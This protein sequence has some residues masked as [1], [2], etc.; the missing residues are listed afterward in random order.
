MRTGTRCRRGGEGPC[1]RDAG[2][3]CPGIPRAAPIRLAAAPLAGGP[4]AASVAI[5]RTP[6]EAVRSRMGQRASGAAGAPAGRSAGRRIPSGRGAR[7]ATPP[8]PQRVQEAA[9]GGS[10][11]EGACGE[12]GE[13]G[14][15]AGG[16]G[17]GRLQGRADPMPTGVVCDPALGPWPG[18]R[19]RPLPRQRRPTRRWRRRSWTRRRTSRTAAG[20]WWRARRRATTP[21][22]TSSTWTRGCQR[23]WPSTQ[24]WRLARR[25][26]APRRHSH[27]HPLPAPPAVL[28]SHACYAVALAADGSAAVGG[29]TRDAEALLGGQARLL[30]PQG[31]RG[32][33]PGECGVGCYPGG[34]ST[35]LRL[36]PRLPLP[37]RL[38]QR[39]APRGGRRALHRRPPPL[40]A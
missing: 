13:A 27:R 39:G 34:G 11:R 22:R 36:L 32:Q 5:P 9:E 20:R 35:R 18:P 14:R 24:I 33:D 25:R 38:H 23:S 4:D 16:A 19:R 30:R 8:P 6:R 3:R 40:S 26:G 10:R 31:R 28:P 17:P 7:P 12:E 2:A 21:T 29:G 15:G 1:P 37:A